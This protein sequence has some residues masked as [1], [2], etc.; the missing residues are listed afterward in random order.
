MEV[1]PKQSRE[2][3]RIVPR[4]IEPAF[5]HELS[6]TLTASQTV[7]RTA[8]EEASIREIKERLLDRGALTIEPLEGDPFTLSQEHIPTGEGVTIYTPDGGIKKQSLAQ[9]EAERAKDRAAA[10]FFKRTQNHSEPEKLS[11][12]FARRIGGWFKNLFARLFSKF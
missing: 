6:A 7:E 5:S 1:I 9:Y 10:L 3:A 2:Q 4:E 11:T 8:E 12:H